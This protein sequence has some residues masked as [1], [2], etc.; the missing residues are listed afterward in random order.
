MSRG[1]RVEISSSAPTCTLPGPTNASGPG[2][3]AGRSLNQENKHTPFVRIEPSSKLIGGHL[4]QLDAVPV[5]ILGD[6]IYAEEEVERG[7][8][9]GVAPGN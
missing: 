7:G 5:L 9:P 1:D 8:D 3:H 4:V 2:S 6:D